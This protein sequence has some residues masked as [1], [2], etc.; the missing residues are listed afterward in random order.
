M[1]HNV[2]AITSMTEST[3]DVT[4]GEIARTMA[5]MDQRMERVVEDH[6]KRLRRIEKWVYL[7]PPTVIT[8]GVAVALAIMH[9]AP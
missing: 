4:M 1:G 7:L 8:A 2:G 5:R 9:G 3:S 6:E